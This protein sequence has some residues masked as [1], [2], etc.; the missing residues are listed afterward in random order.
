MTMRTTWWSVMARLP[1][2]Y[3]VLD[4]LSS[5]GI[6]WPASYSHC[7]RLM[8]AIGEFVGGNG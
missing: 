3:Y 7:D 1:W 2:V 8:A 5:R 6:L 4:S